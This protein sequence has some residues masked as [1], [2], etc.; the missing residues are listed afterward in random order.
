VDEYISEKEQLQRIREWW[1]DNGWYLLGGVVLGLAGLFGYNRYQD[2]VAGDAEAAAALYAQVETAANDDNLTD[3][4]RLLG[5]LRAEHAGSAYTDQA[6]LLAA[7]LHLVR[8]TDRAAAEL[9]EVMQSKDSD[10]A[11][12]AR[13]RL[14]RVLAY[15]EKYDE[16][17]GLLDVDEPGPF[18]ARI[19]DIRG[20]IYSASGDREAAQLAFTEA[21]VAPGAELLDRN[22]VQMKLTDLTNPVRAAAEGPASEPVDASPQ[23]AGE[24]VTPAPA[25]DQE[26][27]G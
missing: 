23:P 25:A 8:D 17:L 14:A 11:M 3:V 13:L 18:A 19:A 21:L 10:L 4:E 24:A 2:Y 26:D 5:V 16:A 27:Q 7:R 22:F 12:V 6:A 15:Q 20:D 1:N 9:R